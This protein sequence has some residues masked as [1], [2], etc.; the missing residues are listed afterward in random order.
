MSH[1]KRAGRADA[2]QRPRPAG[3]AGC[4]PWAGPAP[5]AVRPG[6]PFRRVGSRRLAASVAICGLLPLLALPFLRPFGRGAE[7]QVNLWKAL[8]NGLQGD[9]ILLLETVGDPAQAPRT[10]LI[11]T[12]D[13]GPLRV[14]GGGQSAVAVTFPKGPKGEPDLLTLAPAPADPTGQRIYA[15]TTHDPALLRSTD[16]GAGW[17]ALP[18]PPDMVRI[19]HLVALAG[20]RLVA[21]SSA[22]PLTYMY[23]DDDGESWVG[24]SVLA[25][26][27]TEP[28][29]GLLRNHD[30]SRAYLRSGSTLYASDTGGEPWTKVLSPGSGGLAEKAALGLVAAGAG[31]RV[32]A[33]GTQGSAESA[34]LRLLVSDDGGLN[35]KPQTL[36][37]GPEPTQLL[38]VGAADQEQAYLGRPDGAIFRS[39]DAGATWT[40][41]QQTQVDLTGLR[42]DPADGALWAATRGAGLYRFGNQTGRFGFH[43]LRM[44]AVFAPPPANEPVLALARVREPLRERSGHLHPPL[45]QS[46]LLQAG[47][48]WQ[49]HGGPQELGDSILP[50]PDLAASKLIYSGQYRSTDWGRTWTALGDVPDGS[51]PPFVSAVGPITATERHL[52]A[53]EVPYRLG[54]GGTRILRSA[55]GGSTWTRMQPPLN[56]IV[57][58]AAADESV[59]HT[60]FAISERGVVLRSYDHE[61]FEEIAQIPALPPLRNVFDLAVSSR[62]LTD[63]TLMVSV[64]EQRQSD[65][66]LTYVSTDE[67]ET[68]QPRRGGL[69]PDGRPRA[70]FLSPEFWLDHT[71]FL[72]GYRALDDAARPSLY[73]TTDAGLTW[74]AEQTLPEGSEV[75][76]FSL[77][78]SLQAGVLY[79]AAGDGGIWR[80]DVA[81]AVPPTA[82]PTRT[83]AMIPTNTPVP[84][85]FTPSPTLP[86]T[87]T[88]TLTSLPTVASPTPFASRTPT[89]GP[90]ATLAPGETPAT[91]APTRSPSS[92]ATRSV[93][94]EGARILL[95]AL[96]KN[97]R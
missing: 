25:F 10:A 84:P 49:A 68:W 93:D 26:D 27:A 30:G 53:L 57:A 94:P 78:G 16:G 45:Y 97:A 22:T 50:A 96:R 32:M 37:P 74:K 51:S 11:L 92:T 24:R 9:R 17:E 81:E 47:D 76:G 62:F 75:L 72:G 61:P 48:T 67:G 19:E 87:L 79:A 35:W 59:F 55:D 18:A 42:V 21:A 66:A 65:R 43:L 23:S 14:T 70:L 69:D 64:E 31:G 13:H 4:P 80:R 40:A 73:R 46:Y 60:V 3:E 83:P 41:F 36:P 77:R 15:G 88:P 5:G 38:L 33:I 12:E 44:S 29:V 8:N 52:Y 82:T 71:A 54:V 7:A 39:S 56:G 86:P 28:I 91:A 2:P 85:G 1:S 89:P 58:M 20:G 63:H 6:R 90:S 34:E 95:P